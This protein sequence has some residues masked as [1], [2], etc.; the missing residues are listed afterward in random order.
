MSQPT[1]GN[2]SREVTVG[3]DLSDK[4]SY[5]CVLDAAGELLQEGRVK[6]TPHALE[7]LF[8]GME[9]ARVALETGTHSPWVSRLLEG[10][11]HEVIVANARRIPVVCDVERRNDRTD[12]RTLAEVAHARPQLL[13]P[14]RPRPEEA[15]L[16][17]ARVRA[18]DSLVQTRTKLINH[19]RGAVKSMGGRIPSCSAPAFA[20]IAAESLP[21]KLKPV[22]T[23]HLRIIEQLTAEIREHEK[24]IEH[25]ADEVY[26]ETDL[27]RQIKGVGAI[28]ALTFVLTVVDPVRFPHSRDVPAYFGLT[29]RE[30]DSGESHPQLRI[31]KAGDCLMRRLLVGSA[32][33]I[34]SRGPDTDLKRHGLKI[35]KHGGKNARKRAAVAVARKLALV[36][37]RL[38]VTGEVY[39]PLRNSKKAERGGRRAGEAKRR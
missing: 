18:R 27:L 2:S 12:A 26:P 32:H 10:L 7:R 15:Q 16:S 39:E 29:P 8:A 31:T 38:W 35:A 1:T 9:P 30:K 25:L 4:D 23:P 21:E 20:K 17:L 37:H 5:F 19:V 22:L 14:V 6:T 3:L 34:L 28:T 24:A 36:L 33:Y 13:R 11:G